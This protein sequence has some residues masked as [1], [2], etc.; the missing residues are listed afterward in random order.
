M[1]IQTVRIKNFRALKDVEIEFD[2]VT[3]FIGP[4][5]TGKSTVLRAL[6]WFFNGKRGSLTEED[7][8]YSEPEEI[9]VEVK[10]SDLTVSDRKVLGKYTPEGVLTFTARKIHRLDETESM[11]ANAKSFPAFNEIKCATTAADKKK[12]YLQLQKD[13]PSLNLPKA[14]TQP[15]IEEAL[16]TWESENPEQ[17]IDAPEELSTE[18]Y[19]FNGAG[20]IRE[21]FDFIFISADLRAGQESTDEKSSIIGR[22]IDKSIDRKSADEKIA[23]VVARSRTQQQEIYVEAFDSQL[24]AVKSKLD[25]VVS[26]YSPGRTISIK[27]SEIEL[28]VPR[29]TFEVA[30]I[31]GS[32][33]TKVERQGHGF[34]RALLISALQ[35]LA[36]SNT[37]AAESS[38]CLAIEEP[39]LFQHPVQ[40]QTFAKVLRSL[41]ENKSKNT[42]VTYATHSPYFVEGKHFNQIRRVSRCKNENPNVTINSTNKDDAQ[43][44]LKEIADSKVADS[45]FINIVTRD[46]SSALFA[47]RA[48]IVEGNTDL[49]VLYGVGDRRPLGGLEQQGVVIVAAGGKTNIPLLHFILTKLGIPTYAFFD[50]DLDNLEKKDQNQIENMKL[51][52]YFEESATEIKGDRV[53]NTVAFFHGNLETFLAKEWPEWSAALKRIEDTA[54]IS[55]KKNSSAYRTA[56]L[57]AEGKVPLMLTTILT[58]IEGP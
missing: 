27:P 14:S 51:L 12:R 23:E 24:S 17:L 40:A 18:L 45:R 37:A 42:Q 28:K 48:V 39:E 43:T 54:G 4:N 9:E 11:S 34:Q 31:D 7:C 13:Q 53:L 10:F 56:T 1:R 36:E 25:E 50:A 21:L 6:D 49:E 22:I 58:K 57:E 8:T 20:K 5:G 52:K 46:L 38:I 15:A 32:T 29:T 19:G 26:R 33:E 30:V 55:N 47:M 41:S 3:T 35:V 44:R 16:A 2:T